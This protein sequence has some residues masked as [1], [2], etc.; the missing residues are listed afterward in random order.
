MTPARQTQTDRQT[1]RQAH[2]D[3]ETERHGQTDRLDRIRYGRFTMTHS[4]TTPQGPRLFPKRGQTVDR[5]HLGPLSPSAIVSAEQ[6]QR[7]QSTN[8]VVIV[9]WS[10][11]HINSNKVTKD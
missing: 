4:P 5:C 7:L 10:T 1:D 3:R 2:T 6:Q 9:V 8:N 11:C